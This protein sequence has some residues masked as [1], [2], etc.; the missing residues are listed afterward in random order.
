M[1]IMQLDHVNFS[2]ANSAKLVLSNVTYDF[3]EGTFYAIVG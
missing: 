1:A 2:Y 3:E